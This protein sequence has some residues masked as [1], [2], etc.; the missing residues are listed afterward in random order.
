MR[1][2]ERHERLLKGILCSDPLMFPASD[3]EQTIAGQVLLAGLGL[4]GVQR[5]PKN[6][7]GHLLVPWDIP[8]DL[9]HH[10]LYPVPPHLE[11]YSCYCPQI[12]IHYPVCNKPTITWSRETSDCLFQS[13]TSPDGWWHS[14]NQGFPSG[15]SR[16]LFIH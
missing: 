14:T 10:L 6:P 4:T 2:G 12:Q 16:P 7:A 11:N 13:C 15:L 3:P 5:M 8:W 1:Y 9:Y